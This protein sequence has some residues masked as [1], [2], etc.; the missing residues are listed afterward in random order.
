MGM[1]D[2]IWWGAWSLVAIGII[3]WFVGGQILYRSI[4]HEKD[5]GESAVLFAPL[6]ILVGI[7]IGP[8]LLIL[9]TYL[10]VYL[11]KL[12]GGYAGFG[13]VAAYGKRVV[14]VAF[15]GLVALSTV[16]GIVSAGKVLATHIMHLW[17]R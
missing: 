8:G 4:D 11:A 14:Y 16:W 3:V 7:L 17:K 5:D 12:I 9:L 2:I 6:M 15:W 13:E 1:V 10:V